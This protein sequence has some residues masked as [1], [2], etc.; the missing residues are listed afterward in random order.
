MSEFGIH[1]RSDSYVSGTPSHHL[2]RL[3]LHINGNAASTFW[4]EESDKEIEEA[5]YQFNGAHRCGVSRTTFNQPDVFN[6][7]ELVFYHAN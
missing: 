4:F 1:H 3:S 6:G 7:W 5:L 2:N